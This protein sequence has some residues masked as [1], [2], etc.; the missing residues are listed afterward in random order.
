MSKKDFRIS[1]FQ[2]YKLR[3]RHS[4][5]MTPVL[6][7]LILLQYA[8]FDPKESCL[9]IA[10]TN[11]NAAADK[12]CCCKYPN[13]VLS[14]DQFYD[15]LLFRQDSFYVGTGGHLFQ[16][17]SVVFYLSE[18]ELFKNGESFKMGDSIE[19]KTYDAAGNDTINKLFIDD[20]TLIRRT[21]IDNEV[22][23]FREDGSFDKI[24]FRLGLDA[25]AEKV[26]P[27]LAPSGHPLRPQTENLSQNGYVFLQAIVRRDTMGTTLPDTLNFRRSDLGEF[28]LEGNGNFVHKIGYDFPMRLQADWKIL[29][30]G[31]NWNN[32]DVSAWKVQIV[33]NLPSVFSVYQ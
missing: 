19:L 28:F 12:N 15:T 31:V 24:R 4:Q 16:I 18:F 20:F 2:H 8:C 10:A 25:E 27:A 33:A 1:G 17:K 6:F 7:M 3:H 13:L 14:V 21:P 22:A 30:D 23:A 26:I 5:W 9:D 29:F 32:N 11:F